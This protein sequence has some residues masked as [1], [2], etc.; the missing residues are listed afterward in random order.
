LSVFERISKFLK[1]AVFDKRDLSRFEWVPT[2]R[3]D[4]ANDKRRRKGES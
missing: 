2:E 3:V 4:T 1:V